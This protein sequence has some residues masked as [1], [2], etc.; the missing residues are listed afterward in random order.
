MIA[1]SDEWWTYRK[2]CNGFYVIDLIGK[3]DLPFLSAICWQESTA[4]KLSPEEM[5]RLYERN[6]RFLGVLGH[7]TA[8]EFAFIAKIAKSYGSWLNAELSVAMNSN[9]DRSMFERPIHQ[10]IFKILGSLNVANLEAHHAYFGGGTLISLL[11]NEYRLSKDIDFMC[12]FGEGY[13]GLRQAVNQF[14]Y[15]ALF[16]DRTQ[17]KLPR[18]IQCNQYGIRFPVEV[19]GTI[20]KFEIVAEGRITF[21]PPSHYDWLP[22]ACLSLVDCFAEKLL[23]NADRW[24]DTSV[25]SRDLIDLAMLCQHFPLPQA[26][27]QKAESAYPVIE[28]LRKAIANF[29]AKPKYQETC[30]AS[31]GIGDPDRVLLGMK[32]LADDFGV[33]Q[34]SE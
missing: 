8:E 26:A 30:F 14:G 19:D 28:P 1:Y 17:I 9:S 10:S 27:I 16:Q 12:P 3:R 23:A 18:E 34:D 22:V 6:W 15:D 4:R 2:T 5:L 13:R 20:I 24:L 11:L 31:L 25:E 32:A 29:Q 33:P 21:E 7:P